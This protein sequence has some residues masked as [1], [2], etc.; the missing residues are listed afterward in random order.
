[1]PLIIFWNAA[2]GHPQ[3][4]ADFAFAHRITSNGPLLDRGKMT[5]RYE[6]VHSIIFVHTCVIGPDGARLGSATGSDR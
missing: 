4:G 5:S 3:A 6:K 2:T 1:L